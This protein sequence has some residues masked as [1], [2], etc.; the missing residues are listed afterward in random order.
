MYGSGRGELFWDSSTKPHIYI[1]LIRSAESK[2]TPAKPNPA[3][4]LVLVNV[5][6]KAA[7]RRLLAQAPTSPSVEAW[8]AAR[9]RRGV[10]SELYRGYAAWCEG[11]GDVAVGSKTFSQTLAPSRAGRRGAGSRYALAL[12]GGRA[13]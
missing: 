7:L 10:Q 5:Y 11:R 2:R 12:R 9:T 3:L 13:R 4:R 8:V 1:P 6:D